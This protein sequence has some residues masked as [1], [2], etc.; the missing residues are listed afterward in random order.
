M[1]IASIRIEAVAI[2][3][4]GKEIHLGTWGEPD[5]WSPR[6]ISC[7]ESTDLIGETLH[8]TVTIQ[9]VSEHDHS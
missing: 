7:R 9:W 1:K 8:S 3:E 2:T 5:D 6:D 4:D